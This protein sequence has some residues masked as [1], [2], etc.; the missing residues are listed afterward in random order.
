VTDADRVAKAQQGVRPGSIVL[1]H[2]AFAG[3]EDGACDGPAPE[4]DRG[5]LI[6]AVLDGYADRGLRARSLESALGAGELL[7]ETWFA[8]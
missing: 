4:L 8:G 5:R 2:D 7:R 6:A 3:A 1:A